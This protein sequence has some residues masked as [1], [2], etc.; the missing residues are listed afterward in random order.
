MYVYAQGGEKEAGIVFL[1]ADLIFL[2]GSI[3]AERGILVRHLSLRA[4]ALWTR[5]GGEPQ[6]RRSEHVIQGNVLFVKGGAVEASPRAS[7]AAAPAR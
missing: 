7:A 2:E 5:P 3:V 6:E 4:F 1:H